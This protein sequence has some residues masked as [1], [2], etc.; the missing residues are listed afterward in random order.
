MEARSSSF[1]AAD[2]ECWR[3]DMKARTR[4]FGS[5]TVASSPACS[6]I[7]AR[8]TTSGSRA[9]P[10]Q[11]AQREISL[12]RFENGRAGREQDRVGLFGFSAGGQVALTAATNFEQRLYAAA[13]CN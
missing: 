7:A 12:V 6:S 2:S 5:A 1:P 10:A 8:R 3:R 9:L 11:D 13:D 4:P